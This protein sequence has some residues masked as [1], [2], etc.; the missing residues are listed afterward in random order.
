MSASML[1]RAIA[2]AAEAHAGQQDRAG[3]PYVFHPLGVMQD[4]SL[5]G[6]AQWC[7]AVLHD[8]LEDGPGWSAARLRERG[9]SEAVVEAV[10]ALTR[11][12][13][14]AYDAYLEQV[15]ANPI[16]LK[17]KK[18]DIRHNSGRLAELPESEEHRLRNKYARA[19]QVLGM[20]GR[21]DL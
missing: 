7:T 11:Q 16:A 8:V 2:A 4:P 1:E 20:N 6:E 21:D 12:R 17:V 15:K 9:I 13:G 3:R 19:R 18:A 14:E 10:V 5:H